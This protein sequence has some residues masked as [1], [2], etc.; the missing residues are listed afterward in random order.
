MMRK[1]LIAEDN[2]E[3]SDMMRNYLIRAGHTVYQAYDGAQALDFA[4]SV[5]PDLVLLDIMMPVIDGYEVC[6]KLRATMDIPI[7]VVSAKVAEEDKEKMFALGADDYMTKP[8]SFN[9]MNMRVG[10][11]LRRYYEFNSNKNKGTRQYGDLIISSERFEAKLKEE[12]LPLTAK[13]FKILDYLS[14]NENQI[15]P[16]QKL[17]DEVWGIDEYIDENTVA[18]TIARLRDKLA[19]VNIHNVVTVWG[20]GYKWQC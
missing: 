14:L 3:I 13:E 4:K 19:K 5:N 8:F 18:V 2:I 20:L 9:E 11:Q 10:A 7:I 15:I 17:I 16:K 1:I 6:K 12:I